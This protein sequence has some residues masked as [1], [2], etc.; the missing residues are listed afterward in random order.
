MKPATITLAALLTGCATVP[1]PTVATEG[2]FVAI[3][4]PVQNGEAVVTPLE[5]IE[6]SRCPLGMQ[7]V[8]EGQLVVRTQID[9]P[10]WRDVRDLTLGRGERIGGLGVRLAEARPAKTADAA[11]APADYRFRF[12]AAESWYV[13]LD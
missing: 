11:L 12:D 1:A 5:V 6:D 4:R 13:R 7:C 8:W 3:A 10:G 9:G 2:T